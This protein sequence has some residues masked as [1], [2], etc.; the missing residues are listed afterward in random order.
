MT[1]ASSARRALET[2]PVATLANGHRLALHLHVVEGAR[3]GPT[4]G[5]TAGIHGDEPLGCETVR[6]VLEAVDPDT[7]A[8]TIVALPVVSPYAY[9]ALSRNTPPDMSNLN[10]VFPGSRDGTFS[11]ILAATACETMLERAEHVVD[12]HSGG[13][14]AT[15]DYVYIHDDDAELAR[16]FGCELLYRGPSFPGSF[17]DHARRRGVPTVVSELGGGQQRTAHYL[18]KGVRGALN[19]MRHLRMLEGD[20]ELPE[21]QRIVTEMRVIRPHHGGVLLSRHGAAELGQVIAGGDE[22]GRLISPFTFEELE[23]I[24]APFEQ[25]ILVLT[26]EPITNV[27]VGDYGYMVADGAN[28]EPV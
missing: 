3:P 20:V 23:I 19:V 27:E 6:R 2:V 8:G 10:R 4:L 11:D 5:L 9:Q 26:R 18:D 22:L 28:A 12:F 7:L 13:N 1:V 15:V 14:F 21:R 24:R 25:S 17:G 16:A